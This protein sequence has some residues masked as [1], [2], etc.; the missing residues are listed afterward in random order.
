MNAQR[1]EILHIADGDA[2]VVA[3][4]H[5][6]ILN[7]LPALQRLLHQHLRRESECLLCQAVKLLLV[8]AES[9]AQAAQGIG[10]TQDDGI[11][12][13]CCS[14]A[15]LL[16]V[17]TGFALNGLHANF[18]E[19]AH[20]EFTVFGVDDGLHGCTEHAHAVT[21]KNAALVEFHT[22]VQRRLSAKGQQD[23]VGT[24]FLDDSLNEIRLHGEEINL[25]GHT[26]RGLHGCDVRVDEHRLYAFLAQGLQCLRAG[27]VELTG[28]TYL[29]CST[30]KEQYFLDSFFF[31][32]CVLD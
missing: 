18:I 1:V 10:S 22:A 20:K 27:I 19:T 13:L 3:V 28:F 21:F 31:H 29:Q 26:L 8:V 9:G 25:V 15:G 5:Y 7:L 4:A 23:A 16:N 11:A 12:Q 17:L 6:L 14:T 32:R 24:F 2:V 30:A